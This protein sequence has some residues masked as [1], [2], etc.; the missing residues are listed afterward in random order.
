MDLGP[1]LIV[2]FDYRRILKFDCLGKGRGHYHVALPPGMQRGREFDR[3]HLPE[4]T[5]EEQIERVVFELRKNLRY[6]L[7]HCPY[8]RG[9]RA[10]V[11]EQAVL[12][13]SEEVRSLMLRYKARALPSG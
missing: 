2:W 3:I 8:R 12:D 5:V 13:A 1:A 9:R 10:T 11:P 7:E 4:E 6:H